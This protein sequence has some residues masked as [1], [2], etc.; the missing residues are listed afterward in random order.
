MSSLRAPWQNGPYKN[1][2]TETQKK[3][4]QQ[5]TQ[6]WFLQELLSYLPGTVNDFI[7][8]ETSF[9]LWQTLHFLDSYWW[10]KKE[11]HLVSL[12][13]PLRI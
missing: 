1:K 3:T 12:T 10:T 11:M 9:K 7:G 13:S 8:V 6:K 5:N 2:H 4:Q